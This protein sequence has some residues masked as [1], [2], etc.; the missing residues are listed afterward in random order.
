MVDEGSCLGWLFR[1]D[2]RACQ[3]NA[4]GHG[5]LLDHGDRVGPHDVMPDHPA[6][7]RVSEDEGGVANQHISIDL[8]MHV[9]NKHGI[10]GIEYV[11]LQSINDK[12]IITCEAE[13]MIHTMIKR[14]RLSEHMWVKI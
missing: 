2:W 4:W 14:V 9:D 10:F 8:R 3:D 12:F 5:Q 11:T 13:M 7:A 6:R 1:S